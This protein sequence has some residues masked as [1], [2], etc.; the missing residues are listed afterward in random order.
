MA[1]WY[2]KTLGTP[3]EGTSPPELYQRY[4]G[5]DNNRDWYIF[6]A[7]ETRNVVS[8]LH[9]VWHPQ[10]V[11]DVHQQ[12][13]VRLTN[14]CAAVD[15]SDRSEY[16]PDHRSV[17]QRDGLINGVRSHLRRIQRNRH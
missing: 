2:A 13:R 6:Y 10:I 3:F 9:N 4:I 5:H 12:E 8:S 15:G 14:V 16:R 1:N 11:Y 7:P 17:V